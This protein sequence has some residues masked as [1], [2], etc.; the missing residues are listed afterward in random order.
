MPFAKMPRE[1][2]NR[3]ALVMAIQGHYSLLTIVRSFHAST[4][5]DNLSVCT[6]SVSTYDHKRYMLSACTKFGSTSPKLDAVVA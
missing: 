3:D 4:P 1:R 2:K 5:A 6:I